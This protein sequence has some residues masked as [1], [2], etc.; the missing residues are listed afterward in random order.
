MLMSMF[1]LL[2]HTSMFHSPRLFHSPILRT[3]SLIAVYITSFQV[4]QGRHRFFLH[5]GFQFIIIFRNRIRFILL[6]CH[7]NEIYISPNIVSCTSIL[8]LIYSFVFLSH[9]GI[10]ADRRNPSIAVA[11]ILFLSS[12]YKLLVLSP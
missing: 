10:L 8:S 12:S 6:T 5:S 1:K 11:L 7:I 3:P 4:L 2:K 9:L